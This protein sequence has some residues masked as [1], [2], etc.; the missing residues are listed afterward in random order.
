MDRRQFL[1]GCAKATLSSY[2]IANA[3]TA[4]AASI[5]SSETLSVRMRKK[6][7]NHFPVLDKY[8]DQ[9]SFALVADP[10]LTTQT[11]IGSVGGTSAIRYT[12]MINEI[13]SL[14]LR[15]AFA[16]IDGDLVNTPTSSES[17]DNFIDRTLEFKPLPILVYGNHD[18]NRD[19]GFYSTFQDKQ[20]LCNKTRDYTFSFDCG[21]W[22]FVSIPCDVQTYWDE[23]DIIQWLENDLY[24]NRNRPTMVFEHE[25]LMPQGLTQLEWYTYN[26]PFRSQILDKLA[27]YG[28]VKYVVCG[29]V[30]NGIKASYKTAWTYRGINFI[31]APTCTASRP[32]GEEFSEFEAG[33]DQENGDT[34]GGYYMLFEVNKDEVTVKARLANVPDEYIYPKSFR[35]YQDEEPLWF[36]TLAEITPAAGLANGSFENDLDDWYMPYR[37]V[38]DVD[39]MFFWEVSSAKAHQG[40]KALHMRIREKSQ[41]WA[42]T[43]MLEV[44][45]WLNASSK[46]V[47][48]FNYLVDEPS[49][50]GGGYARI[51]AFSNDTMKRLFMFDW[52]ASDSEKAQSDNMGKNSIFTATGSRG[53]PESFFD[54]ANQQE[55]M[56]W[57]LP[58]SNNVW[59][60]LK[61]D[62][63]QIYDA[64][65]GSNAWASLGINRLLVAVGVW[66]LSTDG[67]KNGCWFDDITLTEQTGGDTSLIDGSPLTTSGVFDTT[68]GIA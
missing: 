51:F 48:K 3:S 7:T 39:P 62:M 68:W 25:H 44:Y 63:Q 66:T 8:G 26:M 52:G 46:P 43:E 59:H 53:K 1:T 24:E 30:H 22:H 34:G 47:F 45:Q 67:S 58:D 33:M 50:G 38:G 9:F 32:F 42:Q 4:K 27:K 5:F 2:V 21:R 61:L 36:K 13:N 57:A 19:A 15:P 20:Q 60:E 16:V 28:N 23:Q 41:P 17:W 14:P 11:D 12:Q 49:S 10:Q 40:G 35:P 55:A 54:M 37:Y 65:H 31:T 18:G 6:T 56:L 64:V 29:H